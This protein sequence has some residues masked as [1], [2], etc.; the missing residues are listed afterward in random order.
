MCLALRNKE[1]HTFIGML[2]YYMHDAKAPH[3]HSMDHNV[4]IAN[5]AARVELYAQFVLEDKNNRVCLNHKKTFELASMFWCFH[6]Q[7]TGRA[8]F[9]KALYL[10]I[11]GKKYYS[12]NFPSCRCT[13]EGPRERA[14]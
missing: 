5:L 4:A 9:K 12:A 8:N 2:G 1:L 10:M 14:S 3:F 13:R 11:T 7:N 6:V